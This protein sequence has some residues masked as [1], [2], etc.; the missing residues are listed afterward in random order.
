MQTRYVTTM[1][2]SP[3]YKNPLT[4]KTGERVRTGREDDQ[5]KGWIWCSA[6]NNSGWVPGQIIKFINETEGEITEDYDARELDVDAG[7]E[8]LGT[9]ELNGWVWGNKKN[10]DNFGWLPKEILKLNS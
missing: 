2:W 7:E 1:K 9:R 8:I 3:V 6:K 4:L 10:T 5:W